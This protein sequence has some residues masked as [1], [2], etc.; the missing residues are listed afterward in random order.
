MTFIKVLLLPLAVCVAMLV[1][2]TEL[3]C[4][5]EY[6]GGAPD[7]ALFPPPISFRSKGQVAPDPCPD[8]WCSVVAPGDDD[9]SDDD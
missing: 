2:E 4:L 6:E 5:D 1:S 8:L 9:D 3:Q 7:D